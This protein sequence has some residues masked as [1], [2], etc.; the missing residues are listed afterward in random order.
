MDI[1]GIFAI[2]L[3]TNQVNMFIKVTIWFRSCGRF[4]VDMRTVFKVLKYNFT[5]K[6]YIVLVREPDTVEYFLHAD[7]PMPERV[8]ELNI[9]MLHNNSLYNAKELLKTVQKIPI[10]NNITEEDFI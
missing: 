6:Q 5:G 1:V 9:T 3:Q 7:K 4:F 8:T 10:S 2:G